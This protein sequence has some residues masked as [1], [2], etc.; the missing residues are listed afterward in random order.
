MHFK[1]LSHDG[2]HICFTRLARRILND[3]EKV[4]NPFG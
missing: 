3:T 2:V 4:T 1:M